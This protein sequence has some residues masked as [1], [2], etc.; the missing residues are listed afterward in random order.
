MFS[1][2]IRPG[3]DLTELDGQPESRKSSRRS[4]SRG[5][6]KSRSRQNG[7]SGAGN[8][9]S[10]GNFIENVFFKFKKWYFVS[11]IVLT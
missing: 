6:K 4:G 3:G 5:H 2:G 11:K 9:S 8:S 10:R 1:D 7:Q